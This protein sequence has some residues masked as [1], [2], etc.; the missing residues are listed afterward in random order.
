MAQN[1]LRDIDPEELNWMFG[2]ATRKAAQTALANG[3]SVRGVLG[4]NVVDFHPDGSVTVVHP[5]ST[6]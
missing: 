2:E 5:L 4:H 3:I 1:N 6:K